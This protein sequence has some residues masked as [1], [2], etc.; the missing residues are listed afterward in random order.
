M[1]NCDNKN[2]KCTEQCYI[3]HGEFVKPNYKVRDHCHRTGKY[4]GAAHVRCNIT[5]YNHKYLP[6]LFHHLRGYDSHITL[7]EAFELC[8]TDKNIIAMHNSMEKFMTFGIGDVK[9][10]DAL[11]FMA[12]SLETLSDTLITQST[13][14]YEMFENMKNTF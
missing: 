7:K 13:D 2:F 6:I 9:L 8:G 4:R 3:C 11:Q 12:S 10:I 1:P 5:Y 14:K